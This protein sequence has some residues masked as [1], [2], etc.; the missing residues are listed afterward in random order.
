MFDSL[1]RTSLVHRWWVLAAA[2]ALTVLG[3]RSAATMP[4]DVLPE[5]NAPTVTIVTEA[6]GL[7]PEEVERLVTLPVEQSISGAPRVRRVRSS[8]GVG[9]S[10]VW[11]EFDWDVPVLEARQIV[12][13]R[14]STV[15]GSLP[16]RFEPVLTPASSI[17]G[18]IMFVGLTGGPET[19]G[20]ELRDV[21]EW[22]LR[23][24][25]LS[26]PGVAQV[27]PIGGGVGQVQIELEPDRL[28]AF[29][30][31]TDDVLRALEGVSDASAGGF[32]V[33]GGQEYLI[34]GAGRVASLE[35]L[36]DVVVSES[37]GAPVLVRNIAEVRLGEEIRR[38][39]AA[40]GGERAVV[41]KIQKQPEIGTLELTD[42]IDE[43]LDELTPRLP[44]GMALYRKG[45]RQADFIRVAIDNV[46]TVLAHA[47]I[48]VVIVLAMFL[49]SWRTTLI[50]IVALPL[51]LLA[52]VLVLHAFGA[53][54]N[55][56]T[57][58]GLAIAIGE[59]VD[60]A[61]IDVE[62]V[63]RRLREN[64]LLPSEQRRPAFDVV[65][66]ASREIRGAVVFATAIIL[67]VFSPLFFLSGLEGRLLAPLGIAFMASVGASL[68]V[69]LTVTPVLCL[70]LLGARAQRG[71]LEKG[72][73]A[74]FLQRRYEPIVRGSLR[75]PIPIG[76]ASLA[77]AVAALVALLFFG[78]SFLPEFNE[79]SLN[80]AAATA[81]GTSLETSDRIVARLEQALSAHPHVTSIIRTTGRAERDE[82]ALD[83]NFSELEVGLDVASGERE[84]VFGEV[85]ELAR[86]IP[87]LAITVGQPISHRIEHMLSGVRASLALK[88][89]GPD[90]DE[91]RRLAQGAESAIQ[92]VEGIVDLALE[93]QSEIPML[94]VLPRAVELA[95]FGSTP[96]RLARSTRLALAGEPVAAFWQEERVYEV[97]VKLP[98]R[99][100]D[101]LAL[102]RSMPLSN[103]RAG[104]PRWTE[105]QHVARVEKTLGPNLI[106]RENGERRML[107]TANVAGRDLVGAAQE[108]QRVVDA[109]VQPPPGYRI[110]LGGQFDSEARATRTLL[111]LSGLVL[112]AVIALLGFALGSLRD[113]LLVLVNLPLAL[114][115]GVVAVALGGGLLTLASTVGFVTLFG[116]ASRNGVLM[117]THIRQL[118]DQ[119]LDF[120]EAVVQ[121]SVNRLIPILMTALAAALALIP[122]VAAA[123]EPGNEIQA[124]MAAVILGGL[125]SS[126]LLNLLIVPTLFARFGARTVTRPTARSAG[127]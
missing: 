20:R 125:V 45:F 104:K 1:I 57:L 31:G 66:E 46:T 9:I 36:R 73:F 111:A 23:R 11:V 55:T 39:E 60:D 74:A 82:H 126:T 94:I 37:A 91:L 75:F 119:D 6:E 106:N 13:E 97:V 21:A 117:V 61:I 32:H 63:H 48:L 33:S 88:V 127:D 53:S 51:S 102:L 70:L 64:G 35:A 34:R 44:A 108:V 2:L 107:V 90:R 120:T 71:R 68:V 65:L 95:Q 124:P 62:N 80:I 5:L 15:R 41:L 113:A 42:R 110:E 40:V 96:G 100:R 85:R 16:S 123:G 59:L 115:G 18:E 25:L 118:I 98:A 109:A 67:L 22:T 12:G 47:A 49:V 83:V 89:F 81:P 30:I 56:M 29:G 122:L 52:G 3:L 101:D 105:L 116:I 38:G 92:G 93:Q 87:G 76:L 43:A 103:D 28:L 58:G 7:A 10:L 54:I 24:R 14:L 26:I 78:R 114:I 77:G 84:R 121:G 79:G 17:M 112:I 8:S 4:V 27:V 50:S 86:G 69:A 72:R 99:Y 19:D